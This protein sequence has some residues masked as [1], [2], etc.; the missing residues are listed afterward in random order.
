MRSVIHSQGMRH[1]GKAR[2]F[3]LM[4]KSSIIL[5]EDTTGTEISDTAGNFT[6]PSPSVPYENNLSCKTLSEIEV[7]FVPTEL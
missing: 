4:L 2:S 7:G 6:Y 5:G 3:G 1:W